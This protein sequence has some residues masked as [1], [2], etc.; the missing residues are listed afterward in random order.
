MKKYAQRGYSLIEIAVVL[1]IVAIMYRIAAP[2][3]SNWIGNVQVRTAAESIQNGLQLARAEA[4]RRNA[5]VLFWLTNQAGGGTDWL[6]GCS[7]PQGA[8]AFPENPGDCPGP[9]IGS[10][11]AAA[12]A[13]AT[14]SIGIT[15]IQYQP[16]AMQQT[17][18]VQV[19]TLPTGGAAPAY[20]VTFNSLGMVTNNADGSPPITEIDLANATNANARTLHV[21]INGGSIRLC[22]PSL[23]AAADPR[24]CN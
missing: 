8:G 4:I 15:W 7:N 9:A 2:A 16:A 14:G 23:A 22:D 18:Q 13:Y 10:T 5:S 11:A 3:F 24:G 1:A 6:V 20:V 19:T 21:T 12:P 17:T